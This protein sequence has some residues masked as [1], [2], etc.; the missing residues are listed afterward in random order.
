MVGS[1]WPAWATATQSPQQFPWDATDLAYYFVLV[2]TKDGIALGG[3]QSV[4]D[5]QTFVSLAHKS[6]ALLHIALHAEGVSD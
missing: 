4:E 1:F 5:M 2:T 3:G 6:E